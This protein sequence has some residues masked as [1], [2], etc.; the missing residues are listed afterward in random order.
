MHLTNRFIVPREF[1]N[2]EK[3]DAFLTF[4]RFIFVFNWITLLV[5]AF[6]LDASPRSDI[7]PRSR[8]EDWNNRHATL[9]HRCQ[10]IFTADVSGENEWPRAQ[11]PSVLRDRMLQPSHLLNLILQARFC[12]KPFFF[13]FLLFLS[14][15]LSFLCNLCL[16]AMP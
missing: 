7:V 16:H 10:S 8:G 14:F 13:S 15:F 4:I 9:F 11:S 3:K 1:I 6:Q 12:T 5:T 2:H